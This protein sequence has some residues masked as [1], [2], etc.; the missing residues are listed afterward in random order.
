MG[1]EVHDRS[2]DQRRLFSYEAGCRICDPQIEKCMHHQVFSPLS[3]MFT[4]T[5]LHL[6]VYTC[7]F[8]LARLH[9]HV[10]TCTFTLARLHLHVYTCTFT[11]NLQFYTYFLT[12]TF[13]HLL[14]YT[15]FFEICIMIHIRRI[16]QT[17]QKDT[18]EDSDPQRPKTSKATTDAARPLRSDRRKKATRQR[19]VEDWNTKRPLGK[20]CVPVTVVF[21]K[22][23]VSACLHVCRYVCLLQVVVCLLWVSRV[24]VGLRNNIDPHTIPV[25]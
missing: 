7:T 13:L 24:V 2:C 11:L 9:L 18:E 1:Y 14:F 22:M 5:F 12:L 6:L 20:V 23:S 25:S 3:P 10:Y 17:I 15:Y 16:L 4:L 19:K 8:T 21:E